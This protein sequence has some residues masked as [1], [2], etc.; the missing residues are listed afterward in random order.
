LKPDEYDLL[1]GFKGGFVFFKKN[2]KICLEE[3]EIDINF[4]L[5]IQPLFWCSI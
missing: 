2:K 3:Y 5:K 4:F 1:G